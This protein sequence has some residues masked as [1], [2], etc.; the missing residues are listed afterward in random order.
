MLQCLIRTGLDVTVPDSNRM[1]INLPSG[2]VCECDEAA[3]Q[4]GGQ[5]RR[6]SGGTEAGLANAGLLA[7]QFS[8]IRSLTSRVAE[9]EP[10][11]TVFIWRPRHRNRNRIRNTVP[12]PGTRK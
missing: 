8:A 12:V 4:E 2:S 11:G 3:V 9:P 10:V 6:G 1:N 7:G 5:A